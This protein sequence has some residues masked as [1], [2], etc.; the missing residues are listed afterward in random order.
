[1]RHPDAT[2][3]RAPRQLTPVVAAHT[4]A[5]GQAGIP[6]HVPGREKQ[7]KT[8]VSSGIRPLLTLVAVWCCLGGCASRSVTFD[9]LR[10]LPPYDSSR[11]SITALSSGVPGGVSLPHRD[12][13]RVDFTSGTDLRNLVARDGNIL[14]VHSYFCD[15][16]DNLGTLGDPGVYV[17]RADAG[18]DTIVKR[19]L[20]FVDVSRKSNS[21]SIPL[22]PGFDLSV[23]PKDICFYLTAH[24]VVTTFKSEIGMVPKASIEHVFI[25][26]KLN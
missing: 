26:W 3:T 20:F 1:L 11:D 14:F 19:F 12:L 17:E 24:N 22:E 10:P 23:N 9:S 4:D 8:Y 16:G 18:R 21:G 7:G 6:A 2:G 15:R 5:S 13:I 25:G